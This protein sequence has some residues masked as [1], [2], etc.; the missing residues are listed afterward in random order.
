M[1]SDVRSLA[2][3]AVAVGGVGIALFLATAT[4]EDITT[5]LG[6]PPPA[7]LVAR[8]E[9]GDSP[10]CFGLAEHY[11]LGRGVPADARMA[12]RWYECAA[13]SGHAGARYEM[14]RLYESGEGARR[15]LR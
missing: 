14:G 7:D 4:L 9:A 11:R 2:A 12:L 8:A 15:D 1:P 3:V 10:A 6:P 5:D 13:R